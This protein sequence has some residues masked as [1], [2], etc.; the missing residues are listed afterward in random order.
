MEI[1]KDPSPNTKA[2]ISNDQNIVQNMV[3]AESQITFLRLKLKLVMKESNE[4][5]E[6]VRTSLWLVPTS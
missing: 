3:D 4:Q 1:E 2:H 6:E 5:Y